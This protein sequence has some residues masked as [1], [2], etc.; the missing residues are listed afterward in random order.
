MGLFRAKQPQWAIDADKR[1][2][3]YL[4]KRKAD[5]LCMVTYRPPGAISCHQPCS[6]SAGHQGT[7]EW[8]GDNGEL[9]ASF[10]DGEAQ[11]SWSMSA[12][13]WLVVSEGREPYRRPT[14][15]ETLMGRR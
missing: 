7:H 9:L 2:R 13:N 11:A 8:I 15:I 3:D 1:Q 10:S 12:S 4:A 5:G 14:F 6:L